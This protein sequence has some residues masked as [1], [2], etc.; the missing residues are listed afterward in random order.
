MQT[1]EGDEYQTP[2][3]NRTP[4]FT[5]PEWESQLPTGPMKIREQE[6][7]NRE[8]DYAKLNKNIGTF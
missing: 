2:G 6:R 1:K 3:G 4:S 5:A 8:A 7:R